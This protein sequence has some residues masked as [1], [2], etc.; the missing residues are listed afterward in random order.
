M[1]GLTPKDIIRTYG[2][3]YGVHQSVMTA[4]GISDDHVCA[5]MHFYSHSTFQQC[6][7]Y[8]YAIAHLMLNLRWYMEWAI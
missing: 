8:D 3:L 1:D 5:P 4:T 2:T 6:N 7:L